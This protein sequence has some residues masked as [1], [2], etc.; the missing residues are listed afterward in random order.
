MPVPIAVEYP[1]R[2]RNGIVADKEV[3]KTEVSKNGET[4]KVRIPP[5]PRFGK[6]VREE[7]ISFANDYE[8]DAHEMDEFIFAVGE[9]LANAIEHAKTTETIE[10]RCQVEEDKIVA[11]IVDAGSGFDVDPLPD[12]QLPN[13]FS[14]RGRGLPIMR[15]CTDIFAVHSVPGKGT[16]VVLGRYLRRTAG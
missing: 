11:T 7:V 3:R 2:V 6:H 13:A 1:R 12:V 9:A 4:L 5:H 10:V 15:R 16:A 8:I 14:E